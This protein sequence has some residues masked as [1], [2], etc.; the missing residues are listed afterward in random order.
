MVTFSLLG[1]Y[2]KGVKVEVQKGFTVKA[3]LGLLNPLFHLNSEP[4]AITYGNGQSES[5]KYL[6][7]GVGNRTRAVCVVSYGHYKL[8]GYSSS[9]AV[10][11]RCI[12]L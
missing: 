2:L 3:K 4:T 5:I 1:P 10:L 7:T 9:C 8:S 12:V 6:Y 11:S